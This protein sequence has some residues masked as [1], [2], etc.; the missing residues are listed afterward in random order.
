MYDVIAQI[1]GSTFPDEWIVR[2]NHHDAWVNG[3]S[4]PVSGMAPELEEARAIGLLV[5]QG[6]AP[7]RTLVYAAW[8]GEEPGLL[9]STEWVEQHDAELREKAVVYIN[10]DGNS[11]GFLQASGSHTLEHLVNEVARSVDDPET[12]G[13]VW[14][15]WQ[16]RLISSTSGDRRNEARSRADL[17]IGGARFR[18]GLH[19]VPAASRHRVAEPV[20]RRVRRGRDLPLHLRR[21]LPLLEVRRPRVPVRPCAVAVL[22]QPGH[23]AGGRRPA[24]VR[25]HQSRRHDADLPSRRAGPAASAPGRRARAKPPDHRRRARCCQRSEGTASD[26]RERGGAAGDQ[27]RAARERHHRALARSRS[28]QDGRGEAGGRPRRGQAR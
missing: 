14:K 11:R 1:K 19:A 15:R 17:R 18:V 6:W 27:F 23:P 28:L 5:K 3:A 25:V 22:R 12:K 7:K 13:T 20:V 26:S 4:D 2:G 24:A 16:A 8:D 21:L 9:G 10:S